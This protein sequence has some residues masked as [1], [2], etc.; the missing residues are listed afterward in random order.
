MQ[1]NI[2]IDIFKNALFILKGQ[3]TEI[4][5]KEKLKKN[6]CTYFI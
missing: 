4:K 3:F 6:T 2:S 5:R 1:S